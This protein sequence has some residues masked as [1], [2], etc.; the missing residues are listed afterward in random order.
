V[1]LSMKRDGKPVGGDG[2]LPPPSPTTNTDP[3]A[4][5]GGVGDPE[6]EEPPSIV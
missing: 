5:G 4:S 6:K 2:A 1:A 3:M